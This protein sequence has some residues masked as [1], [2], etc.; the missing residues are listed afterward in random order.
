[1]S[2]LRDYKY[3]AVG[4]IENKN[5]KYWQKMNNQKKQPTFCPLHP[6]HERENT[7]RNSQSKRVFK[8]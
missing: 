6:K 3:N 4:L 7:I 5:E 2:M 8:L 1:S